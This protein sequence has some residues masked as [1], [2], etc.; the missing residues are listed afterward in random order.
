MVSV[1]VILAEFG[2]TNGEET[3]NTWSLNSA[4][5]ACLTETHRLYAARPSRLPE[6]RVVGL[7]DGLDER[8]TREIDPHHA[9]VW[10]HARLIGDD[11]RKRGLRLFRRQ[12]ERKGAL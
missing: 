10:C 11:A 9:Q 4:F 6:K 5:W 2:S 7:V 8:C 3:V 12:V 1:S